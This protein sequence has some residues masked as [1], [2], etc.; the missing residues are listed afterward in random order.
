MVAG[1]PPSS[2]TVLVHELHGLIGKLTDSSFLVKVVATPGA[3]GAWV[4]DLGKWFG[5]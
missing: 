2:S 4:G 5:C 1:N 3:V